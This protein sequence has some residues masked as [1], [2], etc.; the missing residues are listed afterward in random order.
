VTDT[1]EKVFA[2]VIKISFGRTRDCRVKMWITSLP[3]EKLAGDLGN[4]SAALFAH[5][6]GGHLQVS[7]SFLGPRTSI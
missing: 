1:V 4:M 5:L 6:I 3:E 7:M 2:L